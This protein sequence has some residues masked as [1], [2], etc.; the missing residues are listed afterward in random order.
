ME[1]RNNS[2]I[3]E[4]IK[5]RMK[6]EFKA[7]IKE[8][9]FQEFDHHEQIGMDY[10]TS[11]EFDTLSNKSDIPSIKKEINFDNQ[12]KKEIKEEIK[13]ET[14]VQRGL[15]ILEKLEL[16]IENKSSKETN[17]SQEANSALLRNRE[18]EGFQLLQTK[19]E[20]KTEVKEETIEDFDTH[21]QIRIDLI[22]NKDFGYV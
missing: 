9:A 1:R 19:T 5:P 13:F 21:E 6:T 16:P 17:E 11:Q 12:I 20:V 3:N 18:Y 10:I 4:E 2:S 14:G 15:E 22:T 7:E 8:E